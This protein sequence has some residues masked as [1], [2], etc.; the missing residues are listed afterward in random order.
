MGAN[1]CQ[2]LCLGSWTLAKIGENWSWKC[3]FKKK[4]NTSWVPGVE[5]MVG[6][7][8]KIVLKKG[9]SWGWHIPVLPSS[10]SV[11]PLQKCDVNNTRVVLLVNSDFA[12]FFVF[13]RTKHQP[14]CHLR[15]Y[16]VLQRLCNEAVLSPGIDAFWY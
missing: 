1:F 16:L 10:V 8:T 3:Q 11:S 9:G 5:E 15:S 14:R 6:L 7:K 4:K 12:F 13:E 2:K